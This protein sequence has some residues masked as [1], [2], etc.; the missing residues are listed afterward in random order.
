M[1]ITKSP[2]VLLSLF[3]MTPG[4]YF[5]QAMASAVTPFETYD[6]LKS[7]VNQYCDDIFDS[8]SAYG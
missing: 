4:S 3:I 7:A 1:I 2:R 8:S 5:K 6:E